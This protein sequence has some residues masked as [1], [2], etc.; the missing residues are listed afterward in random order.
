VRF[1]VGLPNVADYGDPRL[2]IELGTLAE[3]AGWDGVFIWDHVAY[4]QPG[5]AVAD[6]QVAVAALTAATQQVRLGVLMVALPRRRPWKVAREL[7]SLDVLSG[8]RMMF[9]AGVG[10]QSFEEYAAFGEQDD[11]HVRGQRL[12]EALEVLVGL[13]SGAPFSH[14][15]EHYTVQETRFLPRPIQKPRVPIWIAGRWPA[16]RP[17]QRAARWDGVFPTHAEVGHGETMSPVQLEEI[18]SYTLSRRDPSCGELDVIMEGQTTGVDHGTD[19]RKV[20]TYDAVGLTWWIEQ[21]GWFRGSV[22]EMRHRIRA[23]P[24]RT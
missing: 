12:D 7:A 4:R 9:G 14:R 11:L 16:R 17:F 21:V 10:S 1:A 6:P 2:L 19:A 3:Q 15:G 23:G 13:W 18:V 8:G 20:S 22:S 5:W 24:P